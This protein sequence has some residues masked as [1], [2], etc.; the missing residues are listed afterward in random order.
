M[1]PVILI[2]VVAVV[3]IVIANKINKKNKLEKAAEIGSNIYNNIMTGGQ[4]SPKN[5]PPA[6]IFGCAV[7]SFA[8]NHGIPS[9]FT[10]KGEP[11]GKY[12]FRQMANELLPTQYRTDRAYFNCINMET[13]VFWIS[14][15]ENFFIDSV[16]S[17]YQ[18]NKEW[19]D[20]F[21]EYYWKFSISNMI[22]V[23]RKPDIPIFLA[24]TCH[25]SHAVALDEVTL[26]IFLRCSCQ[27]P[28][29]FTG[30][31]GSVVPGYDANKVT[32]ILSSSIGHEFKRHTEQ[33]A[34]NLVSLFIPENETD[35]FDLD[36]NDKKLLQ[37]VD[38]NWKT[39]PKDISVPKG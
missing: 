27:M 16:S 12:K 11:L 38:E 7:A 26:H 28:E 36:E 8:A 23:M 35:P 1:D 17:I 25:A 3:V 34:K 5:L 4:R 18:P 30:S 24:K 31:N 13:T 14:Y 10:S 15:M 33:Q 22:E 20:K 21:H 9:T 39:L 2:V 37:A 19:K 6:D 29:G 32:S